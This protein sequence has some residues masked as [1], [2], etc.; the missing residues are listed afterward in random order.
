MVEMAII[1]FIINLVIEHTLNRLDSFNDVFQFAYLHF[2]INSQFLSNR[3]NRKNLSL[4]KPLMNSVH[5]M[6]FFCILKGPINLDQD[7]TLDLLISA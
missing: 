1:D 3:F 7:K 5:C 2:L 4:F 6:I